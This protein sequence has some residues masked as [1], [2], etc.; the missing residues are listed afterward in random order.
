M[1]TDQVEGAQGVT[2]HLVVRGA[3]QAIAFYREAFG[4]EEI[5]RA[6][7]PGSDKVLHAQ[8]KVNGAPLMLCDEFPEMCGSVSP[9]SL[10]G[11]PIVLHMTVPDVDASFARALEAGATTV[12]P[13][14]DQFWGDRYGILADPFG[15]RWSLSTPVKAMTHEELQAAT[16][17]CF[18]QAEPVGAA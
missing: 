3:D 18:S 10:G 11:T 8:L 17:E 9:L 7:M 5:F 6:P 14:A 12:M 1:A 13:V 15:H 16:A 4:A 2:P